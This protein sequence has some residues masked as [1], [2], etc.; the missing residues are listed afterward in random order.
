MKKQRY[1]YVYKYVVRYLRE[2]SSSNVFAHI[3]GMERQENYESSFQLW[4]NMSVT[5]KNEQMSLRY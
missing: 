1:N 4:E 3:Y 2:K 5:V